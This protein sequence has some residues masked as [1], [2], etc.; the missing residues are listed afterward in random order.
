MS[1]RRNTKCLFIYL[2]IFST[3]NIYHVAV[4]SDLLYKRMFYNLEHVDVSTFF[5]N[6]FVYFLHF[7]C[8]IIQ[9]ESQSALF[10]NRSLVYFR[11]SLIDMHSLIKNVNA[12]RTCYV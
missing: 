12:I 8:Y 5:R 10:L 9:S 1:H 4:L 7:A 11:L 3:Y 2:V 6:K